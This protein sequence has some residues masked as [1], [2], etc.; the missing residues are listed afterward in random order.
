MNKLRSVLSILALSAASGW[1]LAQAADPP[2]P[3]PGG[4]QGGPEGRRPPMMDCSKVADAE[5]KTR[6]ENMQKMR[7]AAEEKCKGMAPEEHHK[8]MGEQRKAMMEKRAAAKAAE[9]AK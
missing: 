6:C 9:G 8:C 2:P 3:P 5:K 7:A 4:P 1:A